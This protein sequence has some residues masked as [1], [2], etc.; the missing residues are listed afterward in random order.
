MLLFAIIMLLGLQSIT[1]FAANTTDT[2]AVVLG[3]VHSAQIS[4]MELYTYTDGV[5]G[6]NDLL[7]GIETVYD[8]TRYNYYYSTALVPGDY[9]VDGYDEEN[10]LNGG[11]KITVTEDGSN[12]FY[13]QRMYD[14]RCTNS[15]WVQN[16]D[17][18][19]MVAVKQ[20]SLSR[21]ITLG[22]ADNY[23]KLRTSCLFLVGDTV[24]ATFT[25][26]GTKA[27]NY[28]AA[29]IA[30]T[31]TINSA[32]TCSL[33]QGI[34]MTFV[35]PK[36][37]T[38]DVGK[39]TAGNYYT[40]NYYSPFGDPVAG[41]TADTEVWTYRVPKESINLTNGPYFF[42]RVKND[43]GVTYWNF[44][45][46]NTIANTDVTLTEEDL[47]IGEGD[48]FDKTTV[49]RD[50]SE[51]L[52]DTANIYMNINAQ[53]YKNLNK[54]DTYELNIFRNWQAIEHFYNRMIALPDVNYKIIPVEGSD[55]VSI[56]KNEK[57]TGLATMIAKNEGTAIV[58]VTYD[59]M[60]H[61]KAMTDYKRSMYYD[62]S[63]LSATWPE[64]TGVFVVTV[65]KD[66]TSV[67]NGMTMDRLGKAGTLDAEHD[68]LF[69][70]EET[71]ASYSFK[72]ETGAVVT[73]NKSDISSGEMIFGSFTSDDVFT[74]ADGTVTING[75]STG[76]HIIKVEKNGVANYQVIT[77]KQISWELQDASGNKLEDSAQIKANDT[78]YIQF[79]GLV[80]P[81]EKMAGIYNHAAIIQYQGE[82][83]SSYF[84]KP[85]GE[86]YSGVY[87]FSSDPAEQRVEVQIPKDWTGNTYTVDG[88]IN[89]RISGSAPSEHRT[90]SYVTG[91][92]TNLDAVQRIG[93]MLCDLP[94]IVI[95]VAETVYTIT[96]PEE[97]STYEVT[98]NA[99]FETSV[100]L[101]G[102]FA[103]TVKLAPGYVKGEDFAVLAND[104]TLEVTENGDYVLENITEDKTITVVGVEEAENTEVT[105]YLTVSKETD[106]VTKNDTVMALREITVP[107]FDLAYYGLDN[108]YY[109]PDCYR[110][111]LEGVEEPQYYGGTPETANGKVTM[112]HLLI[113]AT[114]IYCYDVDPAYAG[115]GYLK[116]MI[117]S[118]ST[119]ANYL[120]V[121]GGP[122][123]VFLPKFWDF[124]K[125]LNYYLNYE[126][127]LGAPKWGATCDQ[128]LLKD[129][130]VVSIRYNANEENKD[131]GTYYHFGETGD[132]TRTVTQGET[133][134]L[135]LYSVI[136]GTNYTNN[137]NPAGV[138][139][140][141]YV[142]ADEAPAS[143][144]GLTAVGVTD[145]QSQ[146]TLETENLEE[147]IY[148]VT[149][150]THD[151]AV[152][153]LVVEGRASESAPEG[154]VNGNGQ[155]T[156]ADAMLVYKISKNLV[157]GT[158][159]Q[160]EAA[161]VTGDGNITLADAMRIYKIS[162]GL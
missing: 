20:G 124:G 73:V 89:M 33:S 137:H 154:D 102:N 144:T 41:E 101:G 94:Q 25:P 82:D 10:N 37:S 134:Q 65:G 90:V 91:A 68:I 28:V 161:D 127:P 40:Y 109:N 29:T 5:K 70:T 8:S 59:A 95:P 75:L 142:T 78:V 99:G 105:V 7:E 42:Y 141:V 135:T 67:D 71:G 74:A 128:I 107:Y 96:L 79:S 104:V 66:G 133:V 14:I 49:I 131:N 27:E 100:N 77:A 160:Q 6:T 125:N 30:K 13:I 17:Y 106:F 19:V 44:F 53:G 24:E 112:L 117:W 23:G 45:D 92:S 103:F 22:Q 146:I 120:Q 58:L 85:S 81:C 3:G 113:Y 121:D 139:K 4:N 98:A 21:E 119:T 76:R 153:K 51:N 150:N 39:T 50:Y 61:N 132:I 2:E 116:E 123:Q 158:A 138:G 126:Y 110:E 156:L 111:V 129:Q 122:G 63:K 87:D 69:Y 32:L 149:T 54:G 152:L 56:E 1:T 60:Y 52:H 157:A 55:V 62:G 15:G 130:D 38:V 148:Y 115:F 36:G 162:K 147:G 84:S 46:P 80:N 57:N 145:A 16:T 136:Q 47:F 31:P 143:H 155:V 151:P 72:P 26:I 64:F 43:E 18:T 34:T 48:G 97:T 88:A 93:T 108:L 118:N 12:D 159:A 114:E 9:W 83:G 11:I 35:V 86:S 140:K